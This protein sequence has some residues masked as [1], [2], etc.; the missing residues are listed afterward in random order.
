M[1][2]KPRII[3]LLLVTTVPT[4]VVA[5]QGW[6]G[7]GLVT[8][9]VVGGTLSAAG[10]NAI[11][12]W[13]D[14]DIDRLMAR[15]SQRPTARNTV[16]PRQALGL[17]IALGIAGFIVLAATSNFLAAS[18]ATFG[19]LFYVLVYT[20]GLKRRTP[21]AVVI[22]GI[23]GCM[24]VLTGWAA[25]GASFSE[26]MPWLLFGMLFWWQPPHFWALAMKYREDYAKA[27]LPMMPVSWGTAETT[28]QIL[29][30]SWLMLPLVVLTIVGGPTGWVF[31][32]PALVLTVMWLLLAHRLRRT[33]TVADA[34]KLFHFSTVYLALLFILAAIDAAL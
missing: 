27:A 22:G 34:M 6:P 9:T 16:T 17:G 10:A 29:L 13:Y 30:N 8:G 23:A 18:L 2:T 12:N 26:P 11:N 3:E 15:T 14:H 7:W 31:G 24:P 28:R 32:A 20:I 1:V 21:Q 33:Q 4:M 25:T 5:M 19:L